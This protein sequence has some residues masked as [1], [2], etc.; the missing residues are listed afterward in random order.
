MKK[1]I[2]IPSRYGSKRLGGKPLMKLAGKPLIQHVYERCLKCK[3]IDDIYVATDDERIKECCN[4]FNGKAFITGK[5]HKSGTDRVFE[6]SE[7]L[8]LDNDDIIINVQ[9][10]QPLLHPESVDAV[11]QPFFGSKNPVMTTLA[12]KFLNLD[13]VN[14]PKDVKVVFSKKLK[15]LYFSRSKIPFPRDNEHT[16]FFKHLGIY[17]YKKFFLDIFTSLPKSN[18]EDIEKLEQLRALEYGY[19]IE[20]VISEFDS[21]AVDLKADIEQIEDLLKTSVFDKL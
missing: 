18:L 12:Y 20:I 13:E 3:N 9:G 19:D 15:A 21:P 17:A 16:D 10:D 1:I 11:T 7:I 8:G 14:N 5:N 6:A 2:I 4:S